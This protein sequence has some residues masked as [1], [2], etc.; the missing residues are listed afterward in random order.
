[1]SLAVF[2]LGSCRPAST[3]TSTVKGDLATGSFT[4]IS[5]AIEKKLATYC[6][7]PKAYMERVGKRVDF[8]AGYTE[9]YGNTGSSYPL[10]HEPILLEKQVIFRSAEAKT[11]K[12]NTIQGMEPPSRNFDHLMLLETTCDTVI[13][14]L[15]RR[16]GYDKVA[17]GIGTAT[18]SLGHII[19][20]NSSDCLIFKLT[21]TS[22]RRNSI[23]GFCADAFYFAI[24][25]EP[26]KR[27]ND[28]I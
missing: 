1:M 28:G 7:N 4:E 5:A 11:Y 2:L 14:S 19:N 18:G 8:L 25:I 16:S 27:L 22:R 24:R 20:A 26:G 3:S 6:S 23:V 17:T 9:D 13:R 10:R 15:N 21:N 12:L